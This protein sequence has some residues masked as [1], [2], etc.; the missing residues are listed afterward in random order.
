[1]VESE[2]DEARREANMLH[3]ENRLLASSLKR[4]S[5]GK[6]KNTTL[7]MQVINNR[8]VQAVLQIMQTLERA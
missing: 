3:I 5:G 7:L 4:P 1:M 2:R 6:I 8:H